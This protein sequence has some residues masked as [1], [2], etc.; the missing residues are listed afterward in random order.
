[1]EKAKVYFTRDLTPQ[2]V[3]K[4]YESLGTQLTGNIAIKIHSG[5]AG[6][7]NYLRPDFMKPMVE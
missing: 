6:N 1:M 4:M 5:E 3:I 7:Q 2:G